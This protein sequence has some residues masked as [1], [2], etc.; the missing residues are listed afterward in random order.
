M[1]LGWIVFEIA[2]NIFQACLSLYFLKSCVPIARRSKFADVCCVLT[3]S[4]FYTLYL[5]VDV[6]ITD[7][8]SALFFF[9]YLLV[10]SRERWY[11]LGLWVL[12][13]EI[14]SLAVIGFMQT[15]CLTLTSATFEM[16]MQPGSL[17]V[18]FV[19]S[20]NMV[21]FLVIF[22]LIRHM[23]KT[24][25]SLALPAL[26][27]FLGDNFAVY[28]AIEMLFSLQVMQPLSAD[29]HLITAYGAMFACSILSV[30]L[31]HIM[32]DVVEKKN[33]TQVALNHAKMTKDHQQV[34]TGIYQETIARQ[35]DFK[36][37]LQTIEQ[38]VARGNSEEAKAYLAQ[39]KMEIDAPE[40]FVTG[41]IA[42]DALLT[43]K[44][45]AC[46]Q[47][48][49]EFRLTKCPL[50][51]LPI[52]EVDFCAVIGNLLDNAIEGSIRIPDT[53]CPR[54]IHLSFNRVWDTFIIRCENNAETGTIKRNANRFLTSKMD[55]AAVHG[56]GIS[57]I[58]NIATNADGFCN[59][60]LK[61]D[62]FVAVITLPYPPQKAALLCKQ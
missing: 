55:Y 49:I 36:H 53:T 48:S 43:A 14:I 60:D 25:S 16:L 54:Y 20:T 19:L 51:D 46:R 32:T 52:R 7:S 26:L 5:F 28:L 4:G 27:F 1:P 6:G 58:E 61:G 31:Y 23:K 17:R 21:L 30:F 33:Q 42:V 3:C 24:G 50:S 44:M 35:H 11:V 56:Y 15:A 29:W 34:L 57:N 22:I 8:V 39:Y 41:S 2:I 9:I 62:T 10:V 37:Q 13:Q 38:L 18:I 12:A 40:A 45:P 47:N 59:F